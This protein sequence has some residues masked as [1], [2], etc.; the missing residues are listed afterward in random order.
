M[1]SHLL[2]AAVAARHA[3]S[4]S[5]P[6]LSVD[7]GVYLGVSVCTPSPPVSSTPIRA[8]DSVPG[9]S[10]ESLARA[11]SFADSAYAIASNWFAPE[12][13]SVPSRDR[14]RTTKTRPTMNSLQSQSRPPGRA[15]ARPGRSGRTW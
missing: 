5:L 12:V 13:P 9:G 15:F 11:V 14:L 10:V 2:V 7:S 3:A 8:S 6:G 1:P 4:P